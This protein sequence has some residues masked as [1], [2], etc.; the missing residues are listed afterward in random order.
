MK[1][2]YRKCTSFI[3]AK[4]HFPFNKLVSIK[5]KCHHLTLLMIKKKVYI[6]SDK[7]LP[8]VEILH[9]ENKEK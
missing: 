6:K 9:V 2:V 1:D 5:S 3:M 7:T 4:I 8:S